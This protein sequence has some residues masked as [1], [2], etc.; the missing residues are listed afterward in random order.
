M[1]ND[2]IDAF[3]ELKTAE[4]EAVAQATHPK[5]FDLYYSV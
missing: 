2:A 4:C 3:I 5:E 1:S